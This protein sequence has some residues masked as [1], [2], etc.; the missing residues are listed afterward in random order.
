MQAATTLF[1]EKGYA[2]TTIDGIAAEADVAVE[3]VYS[4]FGN[5]LTL[6]KAILEPAIVGN[7]SGVD[8]LELPEV[9]A[10]RV[11]TDQHQ[12]VA[13]LAHLSRTILERSALGHRILRTATAA[14]PAAAD[15]ERGDEQRRHHIQSAYIEMLRANGPFRPGLTTADAATTYSALANPATYALLTVRCGWTPDHY[16]RW[17]CDSLTLLLLVPGARDSFVAAQDRKPSCAG[18]GASQA[19]N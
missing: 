13:G 17:L 15:F 16:E 4:R 18:P 7:Q 3:T 1:A 10:I 8:I 11:M 6:L 2:A 9:A 12:Q 19:Q 14:D 5:K